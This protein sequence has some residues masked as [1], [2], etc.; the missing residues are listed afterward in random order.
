MGSEIREHR[1]CTAIQ[2]IARLRGVQP[3]LRRRVC[4]TGGTGIGAPPRAMKAVRIHRHGTAEVLQV[5][6]IPEPVPA[7]G[8]LLVEIHAAAVNPGDLKVREGTVKYMR[9]A[10]PHTLGRDF[11][12][13]VRE[14]AEGVADFRPGDAVFGVTPTG[15][16]GAYAG[17]ISIDASYVAAKPANT[18]HAESAAL[19]LAGLTAI[20]C[21]EETAKLKA[22]ETILIH[23]AAGGV[24]SFA[25]QY[26]KSIGARVIATARAVNHDYVC[27]LGADQAIDYTATDFA[28]VA[29]PCDVVYDLVGGEA[30]RRSLRVLRPGGRLVTVGAAPIPADARRDDVAVLKPLVARSRARMERIAALAVKRSVLPPEII[31]FSLQHASKAHEL[32]ESGRF[33]GKIV[34]VSEDF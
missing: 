3:V 2:D 29:P 15:Q 19:A 10:L 6:E 32:M 22:G 30:F 25:V 26:A 11:S 1:L 8:Q 23:G 33:R 24:G 21:L 27:R 7:Y 20:V 17:L 16:E 13:V 18:S 31:L 34:L 12:G 14:I 28:A 4:R 9:P 5:D